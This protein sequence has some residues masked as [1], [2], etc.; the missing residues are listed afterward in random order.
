MD[1]NGLIKH[2]RTKAWAAHD[3][4]AFF[5]IR[6]EDKRAIDD[7][8]KAMSELT[9]VMPEYDVVVATMVECAVKGLGYNSFEHPH[10]KAEYL[11]RL[12][13]VPPND[14][15]DEIKN[16]ASD[17]ILRVRS[18]AWAASAVNDYL[19]AMNAREYV[20]VHKAFEGMSGDSEMPTYEVV[21]TTLVVYAMS[22]GFT[23]FEHPHLVAAYKMLA[24]KD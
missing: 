22:F 6:G 21:V 11:K 15:P 17:A 3:S 1:V 9:L 10:L 12:G 16:T 20:A 14:V 5:G 19:V 24:S 4:V 7:Y 8:F 23:D 13:N 2:T 18:K